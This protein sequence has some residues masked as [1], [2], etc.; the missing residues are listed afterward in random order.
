MGILSWIVVGIL[1]GSLTSFRM[2]TRGF[3]ILGY[4]AVSIIGAVLGG[5][6]IA[7]L[8]KFPGAMEGVNLTG[9]LVAFIGSLLAIAL[10][11]LFTSRKNPVV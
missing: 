10:L 1:V 6:D 3:G 2:K 4:L 5:L 7:Y 8:Y 9:I 11:R